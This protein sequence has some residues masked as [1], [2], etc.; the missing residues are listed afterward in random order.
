MANFPTVTM[1]PEYP[2]EIEPL[3]DDSIHSKSEG[4]YDQSRPRFT[5][6]PPYMFGVSMP[7]MT[8]ADYVAIKNH[9]ETYRCA[10]EFTWQNP[11]EAYGDII[12]EAGH[13]YTLGEIVRP[14]TAN[15]R[16]YIVT[17][18][19]NSHATTEPVW[20][21]TVGGTVVDNGVTWTENSYTVRFLEKP[22]FPYVR[23]GRF[24]ISFKL[25]EVQ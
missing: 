13:A 6:R 2:L 11:Q 19:G 10:D 18:A 17:T 1:D 5:K 7:M 25:V 4:G 16:S 12:W 24:N 21:T 20:P 22:R 14:T 23:Y 9:Y 8:T 15:G 3:E